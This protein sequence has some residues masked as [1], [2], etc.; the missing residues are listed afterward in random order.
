MKN[1]LSHV[2]PVGRRWAAKEIA[3]ILR[4]QRYSGLSLLAFARKHQLCYATLLRWRSR[5]PKG[6]RSGA[7]P[8]TAGPGFIPIQID[9]GSLSSDYVLSWP[10]GR[11][12]RIPPRFDAQGLRQLL[13]VLEEGK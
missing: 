13:E 5:H 9:S 12:L 7:A 1:H 4:E 2:G 10:E 8:P 11:S 6:A 3:T